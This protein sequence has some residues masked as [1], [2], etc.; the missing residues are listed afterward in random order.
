MSEVY[1]KN[2]QYQH[3]IYW[4]SLS[5]T[6]LTLT[7]IVEAPGIKSNLIHL[8]FTQ[9]RHLY[10]QDLVFWVITVAMSHP[11]QLSASHP[12]YGWIFVLTFPLQQRD[13]KLHIQLVCYPKNDIFI[14][15]KAN[16]ETC[17]DIS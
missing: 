11:S 1:T 2:A 12:L 13:L 3:L 15:L 17:V 6:F 7:D 10:F 14:F 4:H 9:Y 16:H 5:C 8:F